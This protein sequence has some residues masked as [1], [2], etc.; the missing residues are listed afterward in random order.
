VFYDQLGCGKSDIPDDTTLWTIP[1]FVDEVGAVR[2]ALGLEQIHLLGQSWG[3]WLSIEYMLTQPSGIV[4]LTLANTSASLEEFT[5]ECRRL[6]AGLPAEARDVIERCE[7][8]GTTDTPEY[9]AAM[10]AF[11]QRHLCRVPDWP[12]Y[13]MR[14][15]GNIA[16]SPVYG[17]MNGPSEWHVIGVLKG[18]DRR[19]HLAEITVPTLIIGGRYDEMGIPAQ[20]TMHGAI[21]GSRLHIFENSSHTPHAEEPEEYQRVLSA[22]LEEA[23]ERAR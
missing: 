15:L 10:L 4:S 9:E 11:Y 16:A 3:G 18:W 23:E 13:M 14:S 7:A 2:D 6:I 1:R 22:F 20:E 12:D 5:D 21:G 8:A 17:V 19:D